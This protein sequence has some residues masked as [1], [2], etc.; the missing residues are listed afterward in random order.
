MAGGHE[1]HA[2]LPTSHHS[3]WTASKFQVAGIHGQDRNDDGSCL[4][5]MLGSRLRPQAAGVD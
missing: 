5:G 4:L 1:F 3:A 2:Y